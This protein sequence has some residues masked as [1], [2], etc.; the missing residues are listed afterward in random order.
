MAQVEIGTK[1][2]V[3]SS[4]GTYQTEG[5]TV[6]K[7][8]KNGK[9]KL[10]GWDGMWTVTRLIEQREGTWTLTQ[11][12]AGHSWKQH[13]ATTDELLVAK[14]NDFDKRRDEKRLLVALIK[15][16]LD[17]FGF[18][19]DHVNSPEALAALRS[20]LFLLEQHNAKKGE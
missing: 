9:V 15:T 13:Y 6:E 11:P 20:A 5:R 17:M 4:S 18:D 1:V 10:S 8:Y 3:R 19:N 2:W 14:T 16:E 12:R 7:V